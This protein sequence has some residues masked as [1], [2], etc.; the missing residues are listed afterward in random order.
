MAAAVADFRPQESAEHKIKKSGDAL[1]LS[2]VQNPD[3]LLGVAEQRQ[4]TGM[5]RIVVG[6]AAESQNLETYAR[7]KLERKGLDLLVAN[8]ISAPDA[9]FDVDTNRVLLFD[10]GGART[11]AAGSKGQVA[12]V[13]IE[14]VA[15]LIAAAT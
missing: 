10:R 15:A 3:I 7:D 9:G 8:D 11:E 2:L 13:V 5:P 1:T 14:R 4:T 12:E 6:F